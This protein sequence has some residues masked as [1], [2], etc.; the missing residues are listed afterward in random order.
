[1]SDGWSIFLARRFRFLGKKRGNRRTGSRIAGTIGEGAFFSGL[2]LIGFLSLTAL[3]ASQAILIPGVPASSPGSGL[4]LGIIVAT[5]LALIGG[6]GFLRTVVN[7]GTSVE[8]RT[9]LAQKAVATAMPVDSRI[10]AAGKFPTVPLQETLFLSPG[11]ELRYR[12][13][14][15][16]SPVWG[17]LAYLAHGMLWNGLFMAMIVTTVKGFQAGQPRWVA[18]LLLFPLAY[19]AVRTTHAFLERLVETTSI[20]PTSAEVSNLPLMPGGEYELCVLQAGRGKVKSLETRLVCEEEATFCQGT[21]VRTERRAVYDKRLFRLK[22]LAIRP[23]EPCRHIEDFVVP[24][25]AMHSLNLTNNAIHWRLVVDGRMQ[26]GTAFRRSFP[27]VV[28]P[29]VNTQ[30][31]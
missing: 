1:M 8:R 29:A 22:D 23:D 16:A 26:G 18:T 5:S 9:A 27:V 14:L 19:F 31:S 24:R 30:G 7:F 28:Y 10:A 20:G 12:L 6:G 3:V 21:N 2:L 11:T 17:L 25:D 15:V 4:W 13:P